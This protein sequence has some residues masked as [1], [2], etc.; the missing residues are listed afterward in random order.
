[1]KL[2][3]CSVND[4]G[5][6]YRPTKNYEILKEFKDSGL[7]CVE[8]DKYPHANANSCQ[9]SLMTSIK[10]YG[11]IGIRCCVRKGKAYLINEDLI[12]MD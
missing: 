4:L 12:G 8:I 6:I 5:N 7:I 11:F 3:P 1:M 2:K 10:R 9:T